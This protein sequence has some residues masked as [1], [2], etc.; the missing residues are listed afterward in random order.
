MEEVRVGMVGRVGIGVVRKRVFVEFAG[1]QDA[2]VGSSEGVCPSLLRLVILEG[3]VRFSSKSRGRTS[4]VLCRLF[5]RMI[6]S[7]F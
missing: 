1:S 5:L 6:L 7:R 4:F 3:L 2:G